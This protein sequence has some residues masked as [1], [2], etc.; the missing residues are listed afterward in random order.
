MLSVRSPSSLLRLLPPRL[1]LAVLS[2]V[3]VLVVAGR[4]ISPV[5]GSLM[6]AA[7]DGP[8][9]LTAEL[10]VAM[11]GDGGA[12]AGSDLLSSAHDCCWW[13]SGVSALALIVLAAVLLLVPHVL[14]RAG[15]GWTIRT[16]LPPRLLWR[17]VCPSRAPPQGVFCR[18]IV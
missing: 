14:R 15:A 2:L 12:M 11:P 13:M 16:I 17:A 5:G 10:C 4:I 6:L 18:C 3:L 1:R 8:A 7:S 9:F